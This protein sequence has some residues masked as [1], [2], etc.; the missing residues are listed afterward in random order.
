Q[1][2][3]PKAK[4]FEF[5]TTQ[6]G[7]IRKRYWLLSLVL[8]GVILGVCS[9]SETPFIA[10]WTIASILPFMT[11]LSCTELMRSM[12]YNMTELEMSCKYN[13]SQIMLVRL[14]ILG[15]TQSILLIV[16]LIIMGLKMDG[17][18]GMGILHL[19]TPFMLTTY[20]TLLLVNRLQSREILPIC[21]AVTGG[22]SIMSVVVMSQSSVIF[23]ASYQV[24]WGLLGIVLI[25]MIGYEI[26]KMIKETEE[27]KWH[28]QLTV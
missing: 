23:R 6:L 3:F 27:L 26:K 18:L 2:D 25:G 22:I 16:T 1:L 10:V 11:L 24:I 14:T 9:K 15:T 20:A 28:L 7:Y 4:P 19:I 13:F 17:G 8:L 21:G 5:M 12:A